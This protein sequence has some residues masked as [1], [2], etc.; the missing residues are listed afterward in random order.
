MAAQ[1]MPDRDR[2]KFGF[3]EATP[4][5]AKDVLS[6]YTAY[7]GTYSIDTDARIIR[8][9]RKGN[10]NPGQMGELVRRFEF[11]EGGRLILRPAESNNRLIWER[12]D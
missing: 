4:E 12:A 9:Y 1:I 2:P 7:F 8:H 10:I 6:D 3:R 5:Q 11:A